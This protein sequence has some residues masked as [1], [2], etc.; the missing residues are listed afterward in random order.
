MEEVMQDASW[1]DKKWAEKDRLLSHFA[2]HQSFPVDNRGYCRHRV[3]NTRQHSVESS[4]VALGRL[5]LVP[6]A[7][8]VL[9]LL[10]FPLFWTLISIWL[11]MRIFR[12]LFCFDFDVNAAGRADTPGAAGRQTPG[13]ASATPFFPVTPFASPSIFNWRDMFMSNSTPS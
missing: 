12:F 11:A 7:V 4:L 5:L 1:L 10:S 8:P 9:L 13:S 3:F 2:R 6:C